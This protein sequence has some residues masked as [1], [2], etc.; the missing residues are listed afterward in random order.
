MTFEGQR[1][2]VHSSA[3]TLSLALEIDRRALTNRVKASFTPVGKII[4]DTAVVSHTII[5]RTFHALQL[6][7]LEVK[8]RPEVNPVFHPGYH[9]GCNPKCTR[10]YGSAIYPAGKAGG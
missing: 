3:E 5:A 10:C 2:R 8:Q 7:F 6:I 1:D 9:Q 4:V